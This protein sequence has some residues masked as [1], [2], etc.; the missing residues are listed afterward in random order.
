MENINL[1]QHSAL[2]CKFAGFWPS[3]PNLHHWVS[4]SWKPLVAYG[5]ELFPCAKG[6]FI[7]SFTS[8]LDRDLVLGK[9]WSL[10]D[11][12]LSIKPR[13][14]SFK[15]L[16]E[17]LSIRL[18]WVLLPNLSLHFWE[19]SCFEAISNSIGSFLKV[20]DATTSMGHSTFA[21][22]LIDIDIS[23]ALP[24]DVVLMVGDKPW[25]QPLDYEGLP[26]RC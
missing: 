7:A 3:L 22:L 10:G 23:L 14:S 16:T 19:P 1:Y 15:P 18:V 13:S 9:L 8:T 2:V 17:F 24:M 12:S 25:A 26:F 6:F 21:L 4:D 20:D 11:H 5:I